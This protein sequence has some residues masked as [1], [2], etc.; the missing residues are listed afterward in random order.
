MNLIESVRELQF[1]SDEYIVAG[2]GIM[3][4]LGLK[5]AHDIDIIVSDRLFDE[6]KSQGWEVVAYTYPDKLGQV[7]LRKGVI[8][9]YHD[10]NC[11]K[12]NPS[13]AELMKRKVVIDGINFICLEDLLRFKKEYNRPKDIQDMM[14][15]EKY[16]A[17]TINSN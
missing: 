6:L 3:S 17:S 13:R 5:E 15:I 11:G 16:L 7:Y 4:A 12:F 14:V 2:S 8:E 10:V 1:P 9:I